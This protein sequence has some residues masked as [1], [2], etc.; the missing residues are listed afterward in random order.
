VVNSR[1]TVAEAAKDEKEAEAQEDR[2]IDAMTGGNGRATLSRIPPVKAEELEVARLRWVEKNEKEQEAYDFDFVLTTTQS[3]ID[4]LRARG[5][6]MVLADKSQRMAVVAAARAVK[7]KTETDAAQKKAEAEA[8][9]AKLK[10]EAA[11]QEAARKKA[12]E[13]EAAKKKAEAFIRKQ[14]MQ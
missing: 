4:A 5:Y 14:S 6:T 11:E 12:E 13:K 7:S 10:A 3:R 2:E 1:Q 9:E 8:K